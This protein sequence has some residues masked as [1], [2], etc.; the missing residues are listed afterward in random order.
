MCNENITFPD[1]PPV[2]FTQ[3]KHD[4]Q[5]SDSK[6]MTILSITVPVVVITGLILAVILLKMRK[7]HLK[8]MKRLPTDLGN[9]EMAGLIAKPIGDS[10]LRDE[11][12]QNYSCEVTS[13]SGS[14]N[15]EC[16]FFCKQVN[17]LIQNVTTR[18]PLP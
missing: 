17:C 3:S 12:G 6:W 16:P 11:F 2:P 13:G 4:N 14:G 10:T 8:E 18:W 15:L 1:L 7:N 5:N 9:I